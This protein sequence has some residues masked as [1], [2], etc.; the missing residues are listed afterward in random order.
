MTRPPFAMS[1]DY[2]AFVRGARELHKL[3]V[4]GRDESPEADAIRDATDGPWEGL[5]ETERNRACGLSED[6]F[7][8]SDPPSSEPLPMN[9]QAQA[10]LAEAIEARARG[11]WD[12]A[13]ALLRRWRKYIA[14]AV[15]SYE[16]GLIWNEA[17]DPDTAVLFLEHAA[18]LDPE[19]GNYLAIFLYIL[20]KVD[21]LE[22]GRRAEQIIE[23]A[24]SYPASAVVRAAEIMLSATRGTSGSEAASVVRRIIPVLEQSLDRIER[25][26][27]EGLDSSVHSMAVGLL[28]FCHLSLGDNQKALECY[29]RGLQTDPYNHALHIARGIL[30][31]GAS[32]R[33]IT[34]LEL[35]IQHGYMLVWPYFFLA[36]HYL[37]SGEFEKCRM[38]CERASQR[39]DSD[40]V[41]SELAEWS[42]ISKAELGFP[43]DL[44]RATFEDA[45]RLDPS[46]D[47]A[48]RS[49]ATFNEA[50]RPTHRRQW[51][52][53][54]AADVRRSGF[55]AWR[56]L[57]AA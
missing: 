21:H 28:G 11:E 24:D 56:F 26:D 38:M 49:L 16:R 53:R 13:L 23:I 44:V 27:E 48:R 39:A 4:A 12:R 40:S 6:L 10:R 57:P 29:S 5:S 31:Y 45:I 32:P 52:W 3:T 30:Q 20:D 9:P 14:P 50:V 7:S 37:I 47:R 46:N 19:N 22:A 15:L 1:P 33:A 8:I 42:A 18:H 55:S 36:H 17:G 34:D 2:L 25:K 35:A 43:P 54:S 51:P 41:K